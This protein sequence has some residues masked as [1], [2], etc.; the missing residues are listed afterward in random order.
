MD[1]TSS[2]GVKFVGEVKDGSTRSGTAEITLPNGERYVGEFQNFKRHGRGTATFPNGESYVG[3]FRDDKYNGRGSFTYANGEKY[4]GDFRNGFRDGWGSQYD[5]NGREIISG[6]WQNDQLT[7]APAIDT[8]RP[9]IG[10][11]NG[12]DDDIVARRLR[13][14]AEQETDPDLK[15]SLWQSYREYVTEQQSRREEER[16]QRDALE[17]QQELQKR[18]EQRQLALQSEQHRLRKEREQIY[19]AC[20]SRCSANPGA[21][22]LL[23][24]SRC[25]A[26]S[27]KVTDYDWD[28][29]EFYDQYGTLVWRCRGVQTGQYSENSNCAYDAMTDRR[30]PEK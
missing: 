6:R 20:V 5:R 21:T 12:K 24:M 1:V 9:P 17:A 4:V 19:W 2:D 15:A 29:D 3:E 11:G 23:C 25:K 18:E 14:A 16:R 13:R 27:N 28:W 22:L 10:H 26:S 8:Y 30:W 7:Q